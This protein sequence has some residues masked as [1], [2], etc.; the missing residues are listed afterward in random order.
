MT[1]SLY[2]LLTAK[3]TPANRTFWVSLSLAFAVVYGVLCW[4]QAFVS[5]FVVQDD[6]RQHVFWMQRF[7][8]PD[9]FPKD[10]IADYF[11]SVAPLAYTGLYWLLAKLG[12]TPLLLSKVLP[13]VLAV[14]TTVYCFALCLQIIPIPATA[15]VATLLFNQNFWM[16]DDLA[17]ASP[18][19]FLNLLFL[20]FLF[21]L[22]RRSWLLC[23]VAIALL[24]GFY[25]Q[26]V[27]VAAGILFLRLWEWREGRLHL[28]QNLDDRRLYLSGLVVVAA[29]MLP[30]VLASSEFGPVIKAAQARTLPEFLPGG[31]SRFFYDDFGK[32]WIWGGRSGI[33]PALDPPLFCAALGLPVLLRFPKRFPLVQQIQ[34]GMGLFWQVIVTGFIWFGLAHLLLFKLH[35]PSRY[36]QHN[37]RIVMALS[38]AIALTIL[39]DALFRWVGL[40]ERRAVLTNGLVVLTMVLLVLYPLSLNNFPKNTYVTGTAPTLYRYLTAQPKT[41]LVASLSGEASN[42]PTFAGRSVLV[43]EEYAIPYH[44]GYYRQFRQRVLELIDA[45]YSTDPAVIQQL[46]QKYGVTHWLLDKR[47]FSATFVAQDSWL[48]QYQP[49]TAQAIVQLQQGK[50]PAL[51]KV[52]D[53]CTV[54]QTD[55]LVLLKADC[56]LAILKNLRPL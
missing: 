19:S 9:L 16:R 46:I 42:L 8:D 36:T 26:Y 31:R 29:V 43:A 33:Q 54:L 27:L 39:L 1:I 56:I 10:L 45:Q 52:G 4:R 18:R 30:Y 49:V 41:S 15:F 7:I 34:V 55:Q 20:A 12:I 32:Y 5:E 35:L 28:C 13:T 23:W 3:S 6:A 48:K 53:R 17:S 50:M 44:W 38:A 22:L 21:Y 2:K 51:A 40:S 11:Q 37:L 47:A 25:P 14:L 24:G